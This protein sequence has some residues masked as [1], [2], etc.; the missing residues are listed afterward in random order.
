MAKNTK[1]QTRST[2]ESL[3]IGSNFSLGISDIR[4]V[5]KRDLIDMVES[6]T[7]E[8]ISD[9][10]FYRWLNYALVGEAKPRYGLRDAAKLMQFAA[11]RIFYG[12]CTIAR[13]ELA[14][15]IKLNPSKYPQEKEDDYIPYQRTA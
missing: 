15:D 5:G 7:G 4:G 8:S 14:R 6:A 11:Y 1:A 2:W 9:R 12:S 10:T 3:G 13:A